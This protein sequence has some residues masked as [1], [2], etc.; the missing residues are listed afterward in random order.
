MT[1]KNDYTI[2][3]YPIHVLST[4]RILDT[5]IS[6]SESKKPARYSLFFLKE[7]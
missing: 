7:H 2:P 3:I 6:R 4:N 1:I 5:V